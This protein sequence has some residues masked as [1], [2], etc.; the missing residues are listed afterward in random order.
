MDLSRIVLN[1]KIPNYKKLCELLGEKVK[2]GDSKK[3]QMKEIQRYIELEKEGKGFYVRKIYG[4]I[5]KS[6]DKRITYKDYVE[7]LILDMLVKKTDKNSETISVGKFFETIC[8]ANENYSF[9]REYTKELPEALNVEDNSIYE[10]YL[11]S[12]PRL[13]QALESG[14]KGL[15]S[16]SLIY[17]S[18]VIIINIYENEETTYRVAEKDE[19]E[20]ILNCEKRI[21]EKMNYASKR[22]V[23]LARKYKEFTREVNKLLKVACNINFYFNGYDVI[24]TEYAREEQRELKYLLSKEELEE[25]Q[26][27]L[28]SLIVNSISKNAKK[29]LD[30]DAKKIRVG[31]GRARDED[32]NNL[33]KSVA[34]SEDVPKLIT[35]LI[36]LEKNDLKQRVVE[37]RKK[38]DRED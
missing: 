14:L 27:E 11:A 23:L 18:N 6:E 33:E 31:F 8:L 30:K 15:R 19:V 34:Y 36:S 24:F 35:G 5:L 10:F 12:Y 21:L 2:G 17:W 16:K 37:I 28:N 3:A 32:Y 7:K 29:R 13:K 4:N 20:F 25:N 22:R 9:C 38:R 1:E 26:M